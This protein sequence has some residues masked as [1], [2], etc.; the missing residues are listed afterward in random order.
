VAV[1][2]QLAAPYL[3]EPVLPARPTQAARELPLFT[4]RAVTLAEL[5]A[6]TEP[7]AGKPRRVRGTRAARSITT[8]FEWLSRVAARKPVRTHPTTAD[9]RSVI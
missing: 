8:P 7:P 4:P 9:T 5:L 2:D 3:P 1:A 6:E